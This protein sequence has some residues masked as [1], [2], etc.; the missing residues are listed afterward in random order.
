LEEKGY[1][2]R[3]MTQV[4][5]EILKHGE[6]AVMATTCTGPLK[7][8]LVTGT[9]LSLIKRRMI[10]ES[11]CQ[12]DTYGYLKFHS[13]KLL[14]GEK[15]FGEL[16]FFPIDLPPEFAEVDGFLGMDFLRT[17]IVYVDYSNKLLYVQ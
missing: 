5:F 16:S 12:C 17:H 1:C 3:T 8:Q 2:L 13:N 4:P 6:V 15:D 11:S 9:T 14:L 10:Q 7:L